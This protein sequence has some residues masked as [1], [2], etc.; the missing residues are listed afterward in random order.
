[1]T[2]RAEQLGL[3]RDSADRVQ[4]TRDVSD[5]YN[6]PQD[7]MRTLASQPSACGLFRLGE[8]QRVLSRLKTKAATTTLNGS[9]TV[10]QHNAHKR[11]LDSLRKRSD[12]ESMR[13]SRRRESVG[14][15][16]TGTESDNSVWLKIVEIRDTTSRKAGTHTIVGKVVVRTQ[17]TG[18]TI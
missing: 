9:Q 16:T 15:H 11:S 8:F 5:P 12:V 4:C 17:P 18:A 3:D 7:C 2:R 6:L 13:S 14:S 1:M 10:I